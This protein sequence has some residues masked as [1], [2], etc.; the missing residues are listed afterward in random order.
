MENK[1]NHTGLENINF[2]KMKTN[3]SHESN[4]VKAF[5]KKSPR[6]KEKPNLINNNI[7]NNSTSISQRKDTKMNSRKRAL[8]N[9]TDILKDNKYLMAEG[10]DFVKALAER[11]EE[12]LAKAYPEIDFDYQKTLSNM[13]RTLKE[14]SNYKRIN[15]LI[16]KCQLIIFKTDKLTYGEKFIIF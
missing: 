4:A 2:F 16:I 14:I 7:N 12:D 11:V 3:S 8:D 5:H 9:I 1:I 13:T 10:L 6:K 15:Q